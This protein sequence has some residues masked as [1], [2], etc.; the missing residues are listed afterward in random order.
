MHGAFGKWL[1]LSHEFIKKTATQLE[2]RLSV[3][4]DS[5]VIIQFEYKI[6]RHTEVVIEKVG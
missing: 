1:S 6:D 5:E 4:A 3:P 2:Y